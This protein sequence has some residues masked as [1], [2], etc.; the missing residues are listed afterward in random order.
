MFAGIPVSVTGSCAYAIDT[1]A[2]S[3]ELI[4]IDGGRVFSTVH[5]GDA[6]TYT[7]VVPLGEHPVVSRF[8]SD[9]VA[10]LA[11]ATPAERLERFS[12]KRSE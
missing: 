6:T 10:E 5:L 4:G 3:D 1:S 2:P 8:P 7:T 9:F 11:G 12:R